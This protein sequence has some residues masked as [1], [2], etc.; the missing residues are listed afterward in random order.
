MF[1]LATNTRNLIAYYLSINIALFECTCVEQ[2]I[3]NSQDNN[4]SETNLLSVH[5]PNH[6]RVR[7]E[8]GDT[9]GV[10]HIARK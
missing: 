4:A 3:F 8:L 10:L 5:L 2:G 7:I 1:S 6:P 9:V